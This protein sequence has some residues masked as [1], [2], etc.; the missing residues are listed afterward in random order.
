MDELRLA[1]M[2]HMF[3]RLCLIG[4]VMLISSNVIGQHLATDAAFVKKLKDQLFILLDGVPNRYDLFC[5]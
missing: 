5:F 2:G 4:S 1:E 3:S